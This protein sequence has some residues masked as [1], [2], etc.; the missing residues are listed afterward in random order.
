MMLAERMTLA[1][2]FLE[3]GSEHPARRYARK[4][5]AD[6]LREKTKPP[7]SEKVEEKIE[8]KKPEK[9]PKAEAKSYRQKVSEF[10]SFMHH[11]SYQHDISEDRLKILIIEKLVTLQNDFKGEQPE[12]SVYW[13]IVRRC[14]NRDENDVLL[15]ECG[16]KIFADYIELVNSKDKPSLDDFDDEPPELLDESTIENYVEE[17]SNHDEL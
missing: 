8:I 2:T 15:F 4:E 9:D 12:S 14:S 17:H 1:Q 13:D 3:E 5:Q 6:R 11:M 10:Y 16:H 7:V